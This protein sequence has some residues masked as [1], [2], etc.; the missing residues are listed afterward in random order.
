M[1]RLRAWPAAVAATALG[2]LFG[3]H[4]VVD[5]DLFQQIAVGRAILARPSSLGT[6]DFI[7]SYP[8][9][10]YVEDKWLSSVA[11]ALVDRAGGGAGLTVYQVVLCALVA[12]AW[13]AMLRAWRTAPGIALAA[14]AL[15]LL[16]CSFRLE[17][18]PDT[19][20]HALLAA[21]VAL[22]AAGP[23]SRRFRWG[24]PLAL[25]LWVNL[26]GYFV[27]G[28]L[29]LAAAAVAAA[30]G[31]R[32]LRR[33]DASAGAR[34]YVVVLALASAACFVHPQGWRAA[35]SPIEQLEMMRS[36]PAFRAAIVELSPSTDLFADA[37]PWRLGLLALT[38]GVAVACAF[39]PAARRALTRQLVT[40]L[41]VVPWLAWPPPRLA[42]LA[43]RVT[44]VLWLAALVE[45]P[46]AIRE[47]RWFRPL[48]LLGFTVLAAPAI[49]N[50][51]LVAVAALLVLGPTWTRAAAELGERVPRRPWLALGAR[52]AV[53][54]L[55]ALIAWLRLA[56]RVGTDVRAPI[57]TGW[58]VDADRFP[59]GAVDALLRADPVGPLLNNFDSGGY[60]LYRVHPGRRAFIAGNTSM[61]PPSFL[62][63]YRSHVASGAGSDWTVPG[64]ARSAGA[65]V[66]D[67]ASPVGVRMA[68]ALHAD[69][70]WRLAFFDRAGAL[71]LRADGASAPVDVAMRTRE[72]R[73]D[74][75][76]D[77]ALPEWLGGKR[78]PYPSF[79]LGMFLAAIGRPDLAAD[80]ALRL[81]PTTR[82]E[83][84]AVLGGQA[85]QQSGRLAEFAA[86]LAEAF[87]RD[88]DS[89]ALRTLLFLAL[90]YRSDAALNGGAL[91]DAE[92]DLDRMRALQPESCGPYLGLAK[93]AALRRDPSEARRLLS[94]ARRRDRDGT[95]G[96]GAAA[97]ASLR[98]LLSP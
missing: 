44:V 72:L 29:V 18:R 92:T 81:W 32:E 16:T 30:L 80:E 1:I 61:F 74:D 77:P 62:E 55:V 2:A 73:A 4:R 7:Q 57:R 84:I 33:A 68:A 42:G 12:T 10:P 78:L 53:V 36:A 79:N 21:V 76:A 47:R 67:F 39:V 58:G 9:Y 56:D 27:N 22:V 5:P 49:R 65:A 52:A 88:P 75:R 28:L 59:V 11:A 51:P 87:D 35:Y 89:D 71:Y 15:G 64:A 82:A 25:L 40:G 8:A 37:G 19:I 66:V 63:Y 43:Y 54:G 60:L 45:V 34:P 97:D 93:I 26:H 83:E 91:A 20:S 48:V 94:E 95:C 69:P 24:A 86:P 50:F 98:P 3:L 38:G 6:S 90:A 13:Y 17:P 31:D 70:S 85:A 96:R 23:A 14:T 46:S 41:A